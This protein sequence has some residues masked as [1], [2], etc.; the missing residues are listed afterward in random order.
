MK[1]HLPW[2]GN[3]MFYCNCSGRCLIMKQTSASFHRT[4]GGCKVKVDFVVGRDRSKNLDIFSQ[5][6]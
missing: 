5:R 1:D 2:N 3:S 6:L 4:G